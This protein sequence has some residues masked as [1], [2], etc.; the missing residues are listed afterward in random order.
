MGVQRA[1]RGMYQQL[2]RAFKVAGS[3]GNWWRATNGI[4]LGCPLS[5]ILINALMGV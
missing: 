5:L 1:L 3:L 4:V 2:C